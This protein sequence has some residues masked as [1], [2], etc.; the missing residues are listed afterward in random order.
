[1][2]NKK[3]LNHDT[4]VNKYTLKCLNINLNIVDKYLNL[5]Y[6]KFFSITFC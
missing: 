4:N 1:M 2:K 6:Y 5:F 3:R